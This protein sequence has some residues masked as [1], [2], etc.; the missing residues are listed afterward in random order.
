MQ[1]EEHLLFG[2]YVRGSSGSPGT[3]GAGF[4]DAAA[5]TS[6][7]ENKDTRAHDQEVGNPKTCA[8]PASMPAVSVVV[9]IA[10]LPLLTGGS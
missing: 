2:S 4:A 8:T 9:L 1:L 5:A 7:T 6:A 3:V 10:F